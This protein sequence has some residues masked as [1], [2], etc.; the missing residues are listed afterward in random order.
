[1]SATKMQRVAKKFPKIKFLA[2]HNVS[3]AQ[4]VMGAL[5]AGVS[6]TLSPLPSRFRE[7]PKIL[8]CHAVTLSTARQGG[9][10]IS[11]LP[12][13]TGSSYKLKLPLVAVIRH[14]P[15]PIATIRKIGYILL[16]FL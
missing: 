2:I 14:F 5:S 3:T 11:A 8:L 6:L 1:M 10:N 9:E 15:P 12:P 13:P 16:R 7:R 4:L